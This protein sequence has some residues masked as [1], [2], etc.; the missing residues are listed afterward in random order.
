[1]A[2]ISLHPWQEVYD[3]TSNSMVSHT[4]NTSLNGKLYAKL[5]VSLEG[6]ALQHMDSQKHLCANGLLFLKELQQMY[7]PKNIPEVI[8]AKPGEFWS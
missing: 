7:K 2:H 5:L 1:M 8:V 6:Q 3:S 4:T